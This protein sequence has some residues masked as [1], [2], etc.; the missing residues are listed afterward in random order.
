MKTYG[1]LLILFFIGQIN[2]LRSQGINTIPMYGE[3]KKNSSQLNSDK[4]F[5]NSVV[6]EY[7]S[8]KIASGKYNQ[9]AWN[10][11]RM[12]DY[13]TSMKR[14]NQAWLLDDTNARVYFGFATLLDV[15]EDYKSVL[16][17]CDKSIRYKFNHNSIYHM[18]AK[19]CLKLYD[20]TNDEAYLIKSIS[21]LENDQKI[22]MIHHF[23]G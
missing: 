3:L 9:M 21:Y 7:G 2:N 19:A 12:K 16:K 6:N 8:R 20:K 4:E 11:F 1:Y 23:A 17:Y 13:A 15:H 22:K 10:Y 14:F 18:A 5:I